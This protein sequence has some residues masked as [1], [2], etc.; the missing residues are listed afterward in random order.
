MACYAAM[1]ALPAEM[2]AATNIDVLEAAIYNVDKYRNQIGQLV[3]AL[4]TA[5][6]DFDKAIKDTL[7]QKTKAED[8]K[9]KEEVGKG[10]EEI[11][12]EEKKV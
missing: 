7:T 8:N 1:R 9:K 11:K 3:S 12:V 4:K 10:V 5:Q 6:K 2:K